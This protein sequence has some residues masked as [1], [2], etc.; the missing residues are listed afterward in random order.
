MHFFYERLWQS[1]TFIA[2]PD[3]GRALPRER[4]F[5]Y[6]VTPALITMFPATAASVPAA[7]NRPLTAMA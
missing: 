1:A 5:V 4:W 2:F 3:K 6:D 7:P